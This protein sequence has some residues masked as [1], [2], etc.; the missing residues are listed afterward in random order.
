MKR[1]TGMVFAAIALAAA[2]ELLLPDSP[3]QPPAK[4]PFFLY[5]LAAAAAAFVV[6]TVIGRF[7]PGFAAR[8]A[9]KAAFHTAVFLALNAFNLATKKFALL[10]PIFF[11]APDRVLGV[12][13]MD[14]AYLVFECLGASGKLLFS[15]FLTGALAG[16]VTG[17]AVG[18]S[19]RAAYWV[20]PVVRILGPIPPTAWIPIVLVAFPTTFLGGAFLIALSVWF[21]TAV[22]TSSGIANVLNAFFEVSSTLGANR[23]YQIFHVGIPAAMPFIFIG[24][25]TGSCSSFITLM[26]AEMLGVKNGLG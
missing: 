18:F 11:P 5:S 10:P 17:I 25:F 6:M 19:K 9:D 1:G 24:L 4:Q 3:R 8:L 14:R 22:M 15:G 16:L 7:K 2:F 21:P 23:R 12:L 13:I 20:N 26:T